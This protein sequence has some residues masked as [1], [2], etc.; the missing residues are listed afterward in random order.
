M[1]TTKS[2]CGCAGGGTTAARTSNA[3]RAAVV[4]SAARASAPSAS[5]AAVPT[6]TASGGGTIVLDGFRAL[7]PVDGLFLRAEHLDAIQD[8]ALALTT[9]LAT[10]GGTGVVY[11]LGVTLD[12]EDLEVSPGLAVTPHGRLLLLTSTVR[13][14][15]DD[16]HVPDRPVN[17]FWRVELFGARGTSGSA[18]VYGSLCNDG[19]GDGDGSTI[20]PWR[21]EGVELRLT[22]DS[23]AGLD[24]VGTDRRVNWLAS[25][26][27]ERERATGGPWLTPAAAAGTIAPVRSHDW[28]DATPLPG[29]AG[30]PLAL[31]QSVAGSY[32]LD[33]WAAR[34]LVD[35]PLAGAAW[36]NRL[37][38][39]PWAVFLA[40]VLQFQAEL[41]TT[42]VQSGLTGVGAVHAQASAKELLEETQRFISGLSE[43]DPMRGRKVFQR[44]EEVVD[45]VAE[46]PADPSGASS[47][48]RADLGELPPAG[49][50]Q[51]DEHRKDLEGVVTAFFGDHV[52][53]RF[54]R[55]R[56]DQVAD[57]VLA[58]Q[59]RDRIPLDPVTADRPKVDV[60][61]PA[62]PADRPEL[63]AAS[64][65]WVA[66]V[67]RGPEEVAEAAPPATEDVDVY[68]YTVDADAVARLDRVFTRKDLQSAQAVGTLTFPQGSWAYPGGEVARKVLDSIVGSSP[69]MMVGLTR[70]DDTPLV[71]LRAGL[72]GTS[73][74]SGASLPVRAWPDQP[75]EAIVVV[76]P[77]VLN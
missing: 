29:E 48:A 20:Q 65:G 61:I 33:V 12:G 13:V 39:R 30:V 16:S 8:Y 50:L 73:L 25:A 26:Y 5:T 52:D 10:A 74:D 62:E 54:R 24:G 77:I 64:Y 23:L 27:F 49:Y 2:D 18:P 43:K 58:A 17:G 14:T 32:R 76:V 68:V 70:G 75:V 56:A 19:C 51:V 67:R 53:V 6:V 34:R 35:G 15:L 71:A 3:T 46:E 42:G 59:S 57:E 40:Q 63:V 66:F 7:N 41:A 1:T 72:F 45:K 44:L 31:V 69:V 11:G 55:L 4:R 36:R 28:E 21:E 37:A 38:M 47:A 60:L 22:P 9:A